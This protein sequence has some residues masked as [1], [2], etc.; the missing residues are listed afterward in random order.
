[1]EV[2]ARYYAITEE[3][4][5]KHVSAEIPDRFYDEENELW[6]NVVIKMIHK[7]CGEHNQN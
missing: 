4:I 5:E 2:L 6:D 3:E 7:L 1:M